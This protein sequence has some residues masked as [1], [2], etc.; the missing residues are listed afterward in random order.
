MKIKNN[1]STFFYFKKRKVDPIQKSEKSKNNKKK[2]NDNY[3]S[4]NTKV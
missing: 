4:D 3:K 2:E 1:G